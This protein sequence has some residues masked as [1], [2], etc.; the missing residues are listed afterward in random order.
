MSRDCLCEVVLADLENTDLTLE[1]K[2]HLVD[3]LMKHR[4]VSIA[5]YKLTQA[6]HATLTPSR[7]F[8]WRPRWDL[9][10]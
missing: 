10:R 8:H 1:E 3:L 5:P 9:Q 6:L 4:E 2:E 7:L